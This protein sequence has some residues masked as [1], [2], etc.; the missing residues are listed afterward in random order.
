M[1]SVNRRAS[2]AVHLLN[3]GQGEAIVL[4]F[5]D[6]SFGLIDAGPRHAEQ[7]V[8]EQVAV[9]RSNL[10]PFRFAALT[11]WDR[12]HAGG[13]PVVLRSYPPDFFYVPG[14]NMDLM[15]RLVSDEDEDTSLAAVVRDV[16]AQSNIERKRINARD[17]LSA[18]EGVCLVALSPYAQL[19]DEIAPYLRRGTSREQLSRFRNRTSLVLWMSYSGVTMFFGGEAES[20]QYDQMIDLWRS[21]HEPLSKY[22]LP[23]A[24]WVKLSH[25][26]AP[27]NNPARLFQCFAKREF[28]A[29]ASA[30][31]QYGHPHPRALS[32]VVAA[33]GRAMCT[34]L[35][36]GCSLI[37]RGRPKLD[38]ARPDQWPPRYRQ[39][40]KHPNPNQQCFSTITLEVESGSRGRTRCTVR[41]ETV[42]ARCPYGGPDTGTVVLRNSAT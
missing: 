19:E 6:G 11:Q 35:G 40:S 22:G 42:Q 3:V 4:D 2:L 33:G 24:D 32:Q 26:G 9:R 13:M 31:G 28:V 23:C 34:R 1:A 41:G 29:A 21:R 14:I 20:D 10:Q 38:P 36:A 30:G 16:C 17:V 39:L 12:D 7:I 8:L 27:Q 18:P 15:E 37:M 5:P 25:H